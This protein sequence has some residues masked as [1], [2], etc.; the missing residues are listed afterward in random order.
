M[1]TGLE[2]FEDIQLSGFSGNHENI[3]LLVPP[4]YLHFFFSLLSL[5]WLPAYQ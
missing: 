4:P 2:T 5:R 1:L 3:D